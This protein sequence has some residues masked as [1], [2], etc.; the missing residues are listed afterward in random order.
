MCLI[1]QCRQEEPFDEFL[2]AL[3]NKLEIIGVVEK[4]QYVIQAERQL[5]LK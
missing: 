5:K 2:T 4:V 3:R 1:T